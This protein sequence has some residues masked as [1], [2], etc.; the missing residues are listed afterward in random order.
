MSQR[1]PTVRIDGV[2]W[3]LRALGRKPGDR[4][5]Y[6]FCPLSGGGHETRH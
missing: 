4:A 6:L 5:D 2:V 3:Q 1:D